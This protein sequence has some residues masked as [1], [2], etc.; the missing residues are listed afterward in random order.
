MNQILQLLNKGKINKKQFNSLIKV[1]EKELELKELELKK[2]NTP[3]NIKKTEPV[4]DTVKKTDNVKKVNN[5]VIK[6]K[7]KRILQAKKIAKENEIK[8]RSEFIESLYGEVKTSREKTQQLKKKVVSEYGFDVMVT[9]K[10]TVRY[11][12]EE[13]EKVID[14]QLTNVVSLVLSKKD[15]E[16]LHYSIKKKFDE[17][18]IDLIDIGEI[19]NVQRIDNIRFLNV[20]NKQQSLA[21]KVLE[22]INQKT[23]KRYENNY[24][25]VRYIVDSLGNTEKGTKGK[26][27][28]KKVTFKNLCEQLTKLKID[29]KNGVSVS[30]MEEWIHNYYP[31]SISMFAVDPLMKVFHKRVAPKTRGTLCFVINNGH[32][33]PI[34]NDD[35]KKD[36]A[37]RGTLKLQDITW[38]VNSENFQLIKKRNGQNN[39]LDYG[40]DNSNN[41]EYNQ[42]IEGKMKNNV[43]ALI[44]CGI[45]DVISDVISKTGYLVTAMDIKNSEIISFQHPIN[46]QIIQYAPDYDLRQ[47]VCD[48]LF[49][50]YNNEAFKWK[51]QSFNN[52]VS[53]L[54]AML[55]GKIKKSIHIKE[56]EVII[57]NYHTR[58]LIKTLCDTTYDNTCFGFDICKSYANAMKNMNFHYPIFSIC[59][60]FVKYKGEEVDIGEYIIDD[61][62]I[63]ELGGV[64]IE[65][66]VMGW[67]LV[68]YLLENKYITKEHILYFKKSSYSID[69]K[70]FSDFIIKIGELFPNNEDTIFKTLCNNFIGGLG[71]RF[72]SQDKGFITNDWQM[73]SASYYEFCKGNDNWNCKTVGDLHF[74]RVQTR[75]RILG[76]NAQI[77]RQIIGQ[78]IIQLLELI[79]LVYDPKKSTLVGYNT[80]SVFIRNPKVVDLKQFP[81]YR[82]EKWKPKMF[83]DDTEYEEKPDI[84]LA[85]LKEWNKL[86]DDDKESLKNTSCLV[87]G[88]GG[89]GKSTLLVNLNTGKDTLVL[90]FTNK[91]CDNLKKKGLENVFTFD[92]Y[93]KEKQEIGKQFKKIQV[94]EY[95]MIPTSWIK[96]LYKLKLHNNELVIQFFGDSSQCRQVCKFG[97][98]FNYVD[99]YVFRFLCGFNIIEKPYI[100]ATARYDKDLYDVTQYLLKTGKLHPKLK[101]RPID[102]NLETNICVRNVLRQKINERLL[103]GREWFI[104]LKLVAK[105]NNKPKEIYNSKVY[106]IKEIIDETMINVED[107]E[108]NEIGIVN[109]RLFDPAYANTCY[110][111][112]GDTITDDYNIHQVE[113]MD[114]NELYTSLTRA[115]KLSQLHLK[116][117]NKTFKLA[118]EPDKPTMLTPTKQKIG[119]VYLMKNEKHKKGYIG[120]TT[121]SVKERFGEHKYDK[122]DSM[123]KYDGKWKVEQLSI[124]TYFDDRMLKRIETKYIA[125]Y[126]FNETNPFELINV[127][128]IP[129]MNKALYDVKI[130]SG[131]IDPEINI[132]SNK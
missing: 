54:F 123:H 55:C 9:V 90:C 84:K 125:Q 107:E 41:N 7:N 34:F 8:R 118:T 30:E 50:L 16:R 108:G 58:P 21:Y 97:R 63:Q 14:H 39:D 65:K 68:T 49:K 61:I 114:M 74:V 85:E 24:C 23:D 80:D 51:N 38:E 53:S 77:F 35:I 113:Y 131:T 43:V 116:W 42:L 5:S 32:I 70:I 105:E 127:K 122:H 31:T 126:Y 57:D 76:D 4:Q 101:N 60:R 48:K 6:K 28:F 111:Y 115:K 128:K 102:D 36:I 20:K 25:V 130:E 129:K 47:Y 12:D 22:N 100:E 120:I 86:N 88:A 10:I 106:F 91:A 26:A 95:S 64:V 79:K 33:Y 59:D 94:D 71:R 52:I 92:S 44:E 104:G 98:Y 103:N 96:T 132:K 1:Y 2:T 81:Q 93:F 73:V 69:R 3:V 13:V 87:I 29:Y 124:L 117:T 109:R 19:L 66:Q 11:D 99:K 112:Q 78:G 45:E 27:Y 110:K 15:I 72:D 17:Y 40:L 75:Q 56:D 82:S 119:Y 89:S 37:K 83:T 121:K 62:Y 46:Q 18:E 67:N